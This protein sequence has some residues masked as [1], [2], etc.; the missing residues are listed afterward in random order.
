MYDGPLIPRDD[1]WG[2]L[3]NTLL[4][5]RVY[6]RPAPPEPKP[7]VVN[8]PEPPPA[9]VNPPKL[10]RRL[11]ECSPGEWG[12]A[13]NGDIYECP[14]CKAWWLYQG[15]GKW[16][17]GNFFEKNIARIVFKYEDL[18]RKVRK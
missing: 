4:L 8:S 17:K 9:P 3:G 2:D 11:H 1:F 16:E 5:R 7:M 18:T 14:G 12:V 6:R 10:V 15:L 13:E